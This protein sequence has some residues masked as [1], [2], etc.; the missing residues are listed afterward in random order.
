MKELELVIVGAITGDV[1]KKIY[2]KV[3]QHEFEE[4]KLVINSGG[5]SISA[6]FAIY[7]LL[8]AQHKKITTYALG[9]CMSMAT[10][11][12]AL[13]EKRYIGKHTLYMLHQ[14]GYQAQDER[15]NVSAAQDILGNMKKHQKQFKKILMENS[16]ISRK[17]LDAILSSPMDTY[18]SVKKVLKF[19][20]ATDILEEWK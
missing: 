8:K 9:Q 17:K 20:F 4:I 11:L 10:I 19:K 6:G 3:S 1:Y 15:V 14:S 18:L 12:F 5:G 16:T 13:G 2:E 7:D